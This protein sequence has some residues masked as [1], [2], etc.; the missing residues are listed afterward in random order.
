MEIAI[1]EHYKIEKL[2]GPDF[3]NFY[4]YNVDSPDT[5]SFTGGVY[6]GFN[7]SRFSP[8]PNCSIR[9]V[10]SEL[11]DKKNRMDSI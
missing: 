9:E 4:F 7:P 6:I 1:P 3:D 5:V 10:R 11:L 2:E 8:Q